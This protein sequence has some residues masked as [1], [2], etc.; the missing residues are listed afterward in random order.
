MSTWAGV[1]VGK[2]SIE[3]WQNTYYKWLFNDADRVRELPEG[4]FIG[5]RMDAVTLKR[6]LE[7]RGISSLSVEREINEVKAL[8]IADMKSLLDE[9]Y[10]NNSHDEY[11]RYVN[12]LQKCSL[13]SWLKLLPVAKTFSMS[14][15]E[16][17]IFIR[18]EARYLYESLTEAEKNLL[19]FMCSNYD[20]YP[21]YTAGGYHFPCRSS[22]SYA[23][24]ILQVVT[25]DTIC[26][27]DISD[28]INSGWVDDFEDLAEYQAGQTKFYERAK[29]EIQEITKLSE[30][31]EANGA[32]QR[33]S[34]SGLVTILEAY[35]SD[36]AKR[37]VLNKESIKRRFVE[38]FEPFAN[39]QKQ[40]K[41]TEIYSR[42][43]Q[44]DNQIIECIDK[45]SF[46]SVKTIKDFFSSVLLVNISEDLTA[47]LSLAVTTRHDIVHRAGRTK[48]GKPIEVT[49]ADVQAISELILKVMDSVDYQIVDGL[50][51]EH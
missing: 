36:I 29:E 24:A 48:E 13:D 16:L 22:H 51:E 34:Y 42:M 43:E 4:S 2:Y 3:E 8:W 12:G 45:L 35:F 9:T 50:L 17:S 6:R 10:A 33:L 27:L 32:L 46:H 5:Y 1:E 44:L 30:S 18:E 7:L 21:H 23:W 15:A 20:E 14:S 40:L 31:A 19:E 39:S 47:R 25:P 28:L 38:K 37:Q 41:I 49:Q 11:L 26:E